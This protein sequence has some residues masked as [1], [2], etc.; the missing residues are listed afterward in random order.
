MKDLKILIAP[1]GW[2]EMYNTVKY[3]LEEREIRS[4]T[5][6]GAL[7]KFLNPDY[8]VLIFPDSLAV[9]IPKTFEI[10]YYKTIVGNLKKY[11]IEKFLKSCEWFPDYSEKNTEVLISPNVGT[12]IY[13]ER[14]KDTCKSIEKGRLTI[15]GTMSD[16]FSWIYYHL[17]QFIF[18]KLGDAEK[19]TLILDTS[20]GINFMSILTYLALYEIGSVIEL[21]LRND[22]KF[23]LYNADPFAQNVESM[24]LNLVRKVIPKIYLP[25]RVKT[26]KFLPLKAFT[27]SLDLSKD[28][29]DIDIFKEF[30]RMYKN[31]CLPFLGAFSQG[32]PLGVLT[33]IPADLNI[34]EELNQQ[35]I[36]YFE[37]YIDVQKGIDGANMIFKRKLKFTQYFDSSL[38]LHNLIRILSN[39]G[40]AQR[41]EASLNELRIISKKIYGNFP[42]ILNRIID[43]INNLKRN[44]NRKKMLKDRKKIVNWT[45]FGDCK[46]ELN[47][48]NFFAHAGLSKNSFEYKYTGERCSIRYCK[49][50]MEIIKNYLVETV[51][52]DN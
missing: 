40:I 30:D 44:D 41:E 12:F 38:F 34:F 32:I 19:L 7:K 22:V 35:V 3:K 33:F 42:T 1:W 20:H 51:R 24:E 49:E 23:N 52:A 25:R 21:K 37:T 17:S 15:K 14:D 43:E 48:R 8:T 5:A 13:R 4:K 50:Q 47:K 29:Q 2:P 18:E 26:Q 10:E 31:N 36:S 9:Y 6:T 16:Y 45:S 11:L 27:K 46:S 39:I 28:I